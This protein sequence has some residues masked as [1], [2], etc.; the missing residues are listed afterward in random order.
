MTDNA[1]ANIFQSTISYYWPH[2]CKILQSCIH[3]NT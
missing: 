1:N 3:N 2:N